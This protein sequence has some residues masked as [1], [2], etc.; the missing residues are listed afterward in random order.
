MVNRLY[1]NII[2]ILKVVWAIN[3]TGRAKWINVQ[4]HNSTQRNKMTEN[5]INRK[6]AF[7]KTLAKT[8]GAIR[9]G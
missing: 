2:D 4:H 5:S 3:R 9:N 8:E 1:K 7:D 6:H